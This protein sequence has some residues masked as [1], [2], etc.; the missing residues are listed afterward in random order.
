MADTGILYRRGPKPYLISNPPVVGEIV[1]ST[2]TQEYGALE[3]GVLI[4]RPHAS[5]ITLEIADERY[6]VKGDFY[7]QDEFYVHTDNNYTDADKSLVLA[8][9]VYDTNIISNTTSINNILSGASDI[10]YNSSS[11][12]IST[13]LREAIDENANSIKSHVESTGESHTFIDQDVTTISTPTFAG[14]TLNG[15]MNGRDNLIDGAKLDTIETG[16]TADQTA[17]EI[18]ELLKTVDGAGS[19]LNADLLD[20]HNSDFFTDASNIV[21]GTLSAD[22][23]PPNI[24]SNAST[25]T[26]FETPIVLSLGG[27]ITGNV[28]INGSEDVVL[29]ATILDDSHGHPS[30]ALKNGDSVEDFS[31]NNLVVYGDLTVLGTS[32][33]VSSEELKISDNIITLN[34]DFPIYQDPIVDAGI[35]INRGSEL[36][37][38]IIWNET[39]DEW[40]VTEDGVNYYK[41]INSNDV[42]TLNVDS[43][44]TLTT[45]R[46]ISL[47]GDVSGVI[48]FDGSEN[49]DIVTTITNESTSRVIFTSTAGQTVFSVDYTPDAIDVYMNGIKLTNGVDVFTTS[50]TEIVLSSGANAGDI[51]YVTVYNAFSVSDTYTRAEINNLSGVGRTW[52]DMSAS[53]VSGGMY[54]NDTG[55]EIDVSVSTI[56]ETNTSVLITVD[57]VN[58]AKSATASGSS[59]VNVPVPNGANYVVTITGTVFAWSELR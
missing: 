11:G 22:R 8:A 28:S 38:G 49:V 19:G 32:T 37:T 1:F 14:I 2:D 23:L 3:S 6:Q 58:V 52:Q 43:A 36:S 9:S 35:E 54:T 55:R 41:I 50:G 10:T 26:T 34:S 16:A 13:T 20:S 33:T 56:D 53:R 24:F 47:S 7:V 51:V 18:L 29:V 42:T 4:W 44:N 46:S 5:D 39:S 59:S 31:S 17:S 21:A 27:H 40:T 45:P 57:G 12:L 15:L 48:S 25:A 30:L